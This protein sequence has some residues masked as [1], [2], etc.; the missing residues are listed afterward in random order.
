[1]HSIFVVSEALFTDLG[2]NPSGVE[3]FRTLPDCPAT[4]A[5]PLYSGT[6]SL[7]LCK[8]AVA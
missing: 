2:S 7:S 5:S 1:M 6:V 3:V 4:H 8:V